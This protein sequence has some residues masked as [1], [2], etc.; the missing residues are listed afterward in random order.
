MAGTVIVC[1]DGS[2][3]SRKAILAGLEVLRPDADLLVVAVTEQPD[4]TLVSG[5][6]FAGG[7]KS[8][9]AFEQLSRDM[10][11]AGESAVREAA[12]LIGPDRVQTRVL[13]GDA[14]PAVCSLAEEIGAAAIVLGS[15]GRGGMKRALLGS[16]SDFVVRNA[17]CPVVVTST[18]D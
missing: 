2:E 12:A 15:R 16:V 1:T 7:T 10:E 6:G 11:M 9:E 18:P 3:L 13:S 14:G 5:T 17:P 8:P 4:P